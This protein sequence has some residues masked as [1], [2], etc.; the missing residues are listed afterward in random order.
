VSDKTG[1]T[2][3]SAYTC[4]LVKV[5]IILTVLIY[6][7]FCLNVA[8][9]LC[10]RTWDMWKDFFVDIL[11]KI[12]WKYAVGANVECAFSKFLWVLQTCST[13]V[14]IILYCQSEVYL[15]TYWVVAIVNS[16]IDYGAETKEITDV[17]LHFH[18]KRIYLILGTIEHI[19]QI[20][21]LFYCLKS[22]LNQSRNR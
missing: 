17:E 21:F 20:Q 6:V 8:N 14:V 1:V 13:F 15:F 12:Y 9:F 5:R 16:M 19:Y 22:W 7:K 10:S 4:I 2:Y 11:M 18:I 3:V